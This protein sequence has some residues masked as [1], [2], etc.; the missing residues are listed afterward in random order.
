M[1]YQ[2]LLIPSKFFPT[3]LLLGLWNRLDNTKHTVYTLGK[4]KGILWR[5]NEVQAT[6]ISTLGSTKQIMFLRWDLER[7]SGKSTSSKLTKEN[8]MKNGQ[9]TSAKVIWHLIRPKFY[10]LKL[11][12]LELCPVLCWSWLVMTH[13]NQFQASL[14]NFTFSAIILVA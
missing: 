11:S 7:P 4:G 14:P 12:S 10:I 3:I 5:L 9:V 13:K 6:Q 8:T 1:K 2:A